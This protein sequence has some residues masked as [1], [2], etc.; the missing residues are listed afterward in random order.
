MIL[1]VE[2]NNVGASELRSLLESPSVVSKSVKGTNVSEDEVKKLMHYDRFEDAHGTVRF[3]AMLRTSNDS[4]FY[5]ADIKKVA[6]KFRASIL[7]SFRLVLEK[8]K[9]S[10]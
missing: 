4:V 1:L 8:R 2:T 5:R 6:S 9:S 7:D 3:A 10:P